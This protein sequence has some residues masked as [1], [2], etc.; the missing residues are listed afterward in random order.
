MEEAK[1]GGA[2][3]ACAAALREA[4]RGVAVGRFPEGVEAEKEVEARVVGARATEVQMGARTE[5]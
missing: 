2:A 5:A 4:A 3:V 1:S